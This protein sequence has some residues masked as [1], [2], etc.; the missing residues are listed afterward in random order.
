MSKLIMVC[1]KFSRVQMTESVVKYFVVKGLKKFVSHMEICNT[2][3]CFLLQFLRENG[4][5]L[6]I[7]DGA[8][9]AHR[10]RKGFSFDRLNLAYKLA[11][12]YASGGK[13]LVV[14]TV[15]NPTIYGA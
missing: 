5:F 15:T 13:P 14:R 1:K 11:S 8:N 9:V 6:V 7:I 12:S 2:I 4:S 3:A 10:G